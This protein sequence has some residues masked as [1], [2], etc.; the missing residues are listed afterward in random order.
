MNPTANTESDRIDPTVRAFRQLS[1]GSQGAVAALVRQLAESE[2]I[3]VESADAPSLRIG[4]PV[5]R[6]VHYHG[7]M[8]PRR[9]IGR[10]P[11]WGEVVGWVKAPQPRFIL[12]PLCVFVAMWG[13]VEVPPC[14]GV[15][16]VTRVGIHFCDY[17]IEHRRGG[18]NLPDKI[19]YVD[20]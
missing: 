8:D 1:P 6:R 2:G 10:I 20:K 19:V 4:F 3:S 14:F 11:G 17:S 15:L 12:D 7:V 13:Q 16:T 18:Y 5:D 9:K